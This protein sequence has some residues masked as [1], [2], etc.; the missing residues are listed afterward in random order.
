M[1]LVLLAFPLAASLSSLIDSLQIQAPEGIVNWLTP[2]WILSLGFLAG[3]VACLILW[4]LARLISLLPTLGTLDQSPIAW[5]VAVAVLTVLLMGAMLPYVLSRGAPAGAN[6]PAGSILD[7]AVGLV[8]CA[9]GCWLGAMAI[10]TLV[11]RRT[12]SEI[13]LAVK[14]GILYPL[15]ITAIVM[16]SFAFLGLFVVRK[17]SQLLA[18]LYRYPVIATSGSQTT[19]HQVEASAADFVDPQEQFLPVQFRRDEVQRITVRAT[20]RIK[21]RTQPFGGD[22]LIGATIDASPDKEGVWQKSPDALS[23]FTDEEVT[24]LYVKNFG[25]QPAQVTLTIENSLAH[26]Q[27]LIVPYVAMVIV[28]VFVLYLLQRAA[29]PKLAAVALSTAKSE[30]VQPVYLI[31]LGV[32]IF[33]LVL[34]IVIPYHTF[35][36]DIRMLKNTSLELVMIASIFV[37][38]WGASNSVS[39]EIEG[40][41]ALTVLSKPV[42]RR[43]FLLGKFL[44]IAWSVGWLAVV[45]GLVLL[46]T[47]AYKPIYDARE[48]AADQPVWQ[49]CY[50]EMIETLPGLT[51]TYLETLVIAALSVA[52]STRLPML[53]N[54][55]VTFSIY[56]LGHLTPLLVQSQAVA[57]AVPAPV[58]FLANMLATVLPVLDHFNIQASIAAGAQVPLDYLGWT[59]VYCLLYSTVAMLVALTLFE[60]RD[61]A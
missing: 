32:G 11:G 51:L 10:V 37:A 38:V 45:L 2:V 41:T 47:V 15:F 27:M 60:D 4:G 13:P 20:Q 8:A 48:G 58:I 50:R 23:P 30:V 19:E 55:I 3:L 12:A 33:A 34:F 26:P 61:L 5:R 40:R 17:P 57:E 53:A 44:G 28:A 25:T 31:L 7:Q 42:S 52:I 6:A 24:R 18:S 1:N 14:E 29:L 21:V 43:D 46:V 36:D 9:V 54:F 22:P 35:G 16:S 49:T 56:T 59:F 39:E